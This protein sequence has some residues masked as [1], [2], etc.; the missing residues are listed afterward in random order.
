VERLPVIRKGVSNKTGQNTKKIPS[1]K[2]YAEKREYLDVVAR[3][4]RTKASRGMAADKQKHIPIQDIRKIKWGIKKKRFRKKRGK[5]KREG[6]HEHAVKND[7]F[8]SV[9]LG[10]KYLGGAGP[11]QEASEDEY[12]KGAKNKLLRR[13]GLRT[14]IRAGIFSGQQ[15]PPQRVEH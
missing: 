9:S 10:G 8:S 5:T 12:A 3:F 11:H 4:K 15:T 1:K 2:N 7:S 6:E 13:E 14:E